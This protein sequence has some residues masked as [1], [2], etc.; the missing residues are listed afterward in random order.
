[1]KVGDLVTVVQSKLDKL[2]SP[3]IG[4]VGVI[5]HIEEIGFRNQDSFAVMTDNKLLVFGANYLEMI[6]ESH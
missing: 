2:I 3:H 5:V 6:H 4:K 1:M